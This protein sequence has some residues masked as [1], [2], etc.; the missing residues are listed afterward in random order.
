MRDGRAVAIRADP[1]ALCVFLAT[2]RCIEDTMTAD[3]VPAKR[4]KP[5][6][7]R[8]SVTPFVELLVLAGAIAIATASYFIIA[9]RRRR[10]R[11]CSRRSLVALLLVANL[12][13]GRGA[14]RAA[15]A[16]D[17]DAPSRAV[18]DRGQGQAPCAA[19]RALLGH[20]GACRPCSS[21]SSR[22]CCFNMAW[23]SGSSDRA[24]GMLENADARWRARI[25]NRS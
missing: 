19:G 11:R 9:G 14:A 5:L 8:F 7:L 6:G 13:A 21:W 10:R 15:R 23:N 25:T 16:P 2:K 12:R 24:R 17:R 4:M 18:A 20:R 3:A 22:R 1:C